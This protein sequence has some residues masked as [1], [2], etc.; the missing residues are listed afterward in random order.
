M[1]KNHLNAII[2]GISALLFAAI[3]GNA[4]KNRYRHQNSVS[5]T[6]LG[7]KDFT[8]DLIVW[9]GS[10]AKKQY[11]LKEAYAS[12]DKDRDIL[13]NYLISKGIPDS[14][15]VFSSVMINKD[16]SSDYNENTRNT[17]TVFTGYNLTQN[18]SVESREVDKIEAVSRTVSEII[19]S[20]VE[21]YSNQ[22]EY[23]YTKL[24]ELKVEMIAEA[25]QDAKIR[26]ENIA[27]NA[28]AALG[29]LKNAS[30]GVFQITGQNSSEDYSWGG[31][32]N[33]T[34]KNKTAAITIKLDYEIK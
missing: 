12:L 9:S 27:E 13:R 20:D 5:V 34:S 25:T 32:Y 30:M 6:G 29:N 26:A 18:V 28:D 10:F 19:N 22:P 15:I 1:I 8:S 4:F 16:F 23:Y 11:N 17:V 21:F 31:A 7:N 33:T 24:A 2:I 3:L 14:S